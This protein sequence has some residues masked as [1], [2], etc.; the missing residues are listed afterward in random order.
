M[1][2]AKTSE[3]KFLKEATNSIREIGL[4]HGYNVYTQDVSSHGYTVGKTLVQF[5]R[6]SAYYGDKP[7]EEDAILQFNLENPDYEIV[8]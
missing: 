1:T 5:F 3:Q 8:N 7:S 4:K 2:N 6:I